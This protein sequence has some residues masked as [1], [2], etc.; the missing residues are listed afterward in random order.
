MAE[1]KREKMAIAD[2]TIEPKIL[3][4]ARKEFLK[5]GF[6]RVSLRTI[7]TQAGVTTGALYKR[8]SGKDELFGAVVKQTVEDLERIIQEKGNVDYDKMQD[9][10]LI[11]AWD[12]N[13][14]YMMWWFNYLYQRYDDLVLLLKCASG[15][16]Y[17]NFTHTW[18]EKMTSYTY[19]Y[20]EEAYKRGIAR[21]KVT[22]EEMHILITSFWASIYEPFIHGMDWEQ[23][24]CH[25]KI[26]CVFFNWQKALD[27]KINKAKNL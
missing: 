23:I 25:C 17:W 24:K 10:E 11:D 27:F 16:S 6:Q 14:E 13:E 26:I 20:Y 19:Q 1:A 2:K 3:E 4:S 22:N 5:E 15:S 8:Y 7:C 21:K 12:M 9:Q 18:V